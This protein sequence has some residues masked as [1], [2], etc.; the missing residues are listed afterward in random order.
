MAIAQAVEAGINHMWPVSALQLHPRAVIV[1][2]EDATWELKV[3]T[4]RYFKEMRDHLSDISC[5][6]R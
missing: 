1:C 6:I 5:D 3:K 2:D 4:V